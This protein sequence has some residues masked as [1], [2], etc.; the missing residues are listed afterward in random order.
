MIQEQMIQAKIPMIRV[1]ILTNLNQ[2]QKN[3]ILTQMILKNTTVTATADVTEIVAK[4]N[5]QGGGF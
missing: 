4:I 1:L 3:R 2:I 5:A